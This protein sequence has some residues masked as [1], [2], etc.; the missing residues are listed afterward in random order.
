MFVVV[1]RTGRLHWL[2]ISVRPIL[3]TNF[4]AVGFFA[5]CDK[6]GSGFFEFR[7]ERI[8]MI[9]SAGQYHVGSDD[10]LTQADFNL[11]KFVKL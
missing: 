7:E 8:W 11:R 1:I 2:N 6:D 9:L 5:L 10:Y 3:G 4:K